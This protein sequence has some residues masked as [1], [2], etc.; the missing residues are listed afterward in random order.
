MAVV[1][2]FK[3]LWIKDGYILRAYQFRDDGN[4]NGVVWAMP[5]DAP[6]P[7][8]ES[9]PCLEDGFLQ[10]PKPSDA[11]GDVMETIDGDKSPW[12]YLCASVLA[13]EL[14]E[15]GAIWHGCSWGTHT[16]LGKDP[17]KGSRRNRDSMDFPSGNTTQ[18]KWR[19]PRPTEWQPQVTEDG[20]KI[21][22]TFYTFSGLGQEAIYRHKD[23]YCNGS[24]CFKSRRKK[25][26]TGPG[27]YVF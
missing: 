20:R 27:G 10:P 3:P 19:E 16:I 8:P 24:Y 6:F 11:L 5:V 26:A 9:C 15:F 4:G 25:V 2:V 17:W 12:S 1:A 7:D 23:S 14:H 21:T 22:V 13:R 18:W